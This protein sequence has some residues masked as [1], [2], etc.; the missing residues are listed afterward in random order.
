MTHTTRSLL[1]RCLFAA[2]C[3][4]LLALMSGGTGAAPAYAAQPEPGQAGATPHAPDGVVIT[5]TPTPQTDMPANAIRRSPGL[6]AVR[7]VLELGRPAASMALIGTPVAGERAPITAA[8]FRQLA[9][10]AQW[11]RGSLLGLAYTPDGTHLVAGSAFGLAIYD[12]AEPEAEPQWVAFEAPF[13]YQ[14]LYLSAGGQYVLLEGD[15]WYEHP[16]QT[17]V[18]HLP[19]GAL[20]KLPEGVSWQRTSSLTEDPAAHT[21]PDGTRA[22]TIDSR[23]TDT[24][25]WEEIDVR[26]VVERPE[27]TP[28]FQLRDTT[29]YVEYEDYHEP[30]GCDISSFGHCGNAYDPSAMTPYRV[31]FAPDNSSL[32]ILYRAWNLWASN[33]FSTLRIYDGET[34]ALRQLIGTFDDP[35]ESFSYAPDGRTLAVAYVDGT[36]RIWDLAS[37]QPTFSARHFSNYAFDIDYS[38]DGAYLLLQTNGELLVR[39]TSDGA[40]RGRFAADVSA[41]APNANQVAL[42]QTDGRLQLLDLNSGNIL[43]ELAAHGGRIASL[44]FSPDGALL[45]SAGLDCVVRGWAAETGQFVRDF[46]ENWTDPYEGE[47]GLSRILIDALQFIPGTNRLLGYGSWSRVA[48]WDVTSGGTAYLLEPAPLEYYEGMQT[49]NPHFPAFYGVDQAAGEFYIDSQGYDVQTGE[50][51]GA[52][53]PP[54]GLPDGCAPS[55]PLTTDGALRFTRGYDTRRGQVCVLDAQTLALQATITVVPPDSD[56]ADYLGWLYLSPDGGQLTVTVAGESVYVYQV[57]P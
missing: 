8:N 9:Q 6:R 47:A 20:V 52:Y 54:D 50:H 2:V 11:G 38:A 45:V 3:L 53:T 27:N 44:A 19:D 35:V 4:A 22:L 23:G 24:S 49:L 30:E 33:R 16:Q 12:L 26:T 17:Q 39:R 31:A 42:G 37:G 36:V 18:R 10:V 21:S 48:R 55:G 29:F 7:R 5:T 57:A 40:L 51:V 13:Y 14:S 46:Q 1:I 25:I 56:A 28:L 34:G 41:A 15:E 32:T 43:Y